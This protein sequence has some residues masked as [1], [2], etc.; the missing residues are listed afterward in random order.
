MPRMERH[1]RTNQGLIRDLE[2]R[3]RLL[4]AR[5]DAKRIHSPAQRAA[6]KLI[7]L[8]DHAIEA[9]LIENRMKFLGLIKALDEARETLMMYFEDRGM[10]A[11]KQSRTRWSKKRSSGTE[12]R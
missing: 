10:S 3:I 11:G 8:I 4:Q 5:I 6:I 1:R 2:E 9:A 7:P 12:S